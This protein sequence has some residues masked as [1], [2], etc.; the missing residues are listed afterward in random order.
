MCFIMFSAYK[1]NI[2]GFS[3]VVMSNSQESDHYVYIVLGLTG[4]ERQEESNV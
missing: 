3:S 1:I 2:N 4:A